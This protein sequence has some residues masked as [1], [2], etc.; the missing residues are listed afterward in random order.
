M[1]MPDTQFA[2]PPFLPDPSIMPPSGDPYGGLTQLLQ[3]LQ[4][5]VYQPP[6]ESTLTKVLTALAE[7]A[8]I[9][10]S[11]DPGTALSNVLQNRQQKVQQTEQIRQQQRN[12]IMMAQIQAATEKA[13]A[14]TQEGAQAR[15]QARE[16]FYQEK[17]EKRGLKNLETKGQI[18]LKLEAERF[19]QNENLLTEFE[20]VKQA[21]AR[22]QKMIDMLPQQEQ[23]RLDL[24]AR[25]SATL[26]DIPYSVANDIAKKLSSNFSSA[27]MSNQDLRNQIESGGTP[28]ALTAIESEWFKR[29]NDK[30]KELTDEDRKIKQELNRAQVENLKASAEESKSQAGYYSKIADFNNNYS[31]SINQEASKALFN[32]VSSQYF[33]NRVTGAIATKEEM[34]SGVLG[35]IGW[36]PLSPEENAAQKDKAIQAIEQL[37]QNQLVTQMPGQPQQQVQNATDTNPAMKVI[38]DQR[39]KGIS[40]EQ[41]L[42]DLKSANIPEPFKSQAIQFVEQEVRARSSGAKTVRD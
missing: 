40:Y 42:K 29:Y 6:Q 22:N 10:A 30:T 20:P 31:K 17:T 7:G 26:P 34:Q 28:F 33:K 4:T 19:R 16:D 9:G 24:F 27:G 39:S 5:Q 37:R 25:I 38:K 15:N 32:Q 36:E 41:I 21:R 18:D 13:R 1:L 12:N 35:G 3:Q 8:S 14:M 2:T 23:A 11:K